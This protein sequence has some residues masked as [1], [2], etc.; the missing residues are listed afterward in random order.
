[1]WCRLV[2]LTGAEKWKKFAGGNYNTVV[3]LTRA[4]TDPAN[5]FDKLMSRSVGN[6]VGG[7][8][9]GQILGQ[10]PLPWSQVH[11][12][13][14]PKGVLRQINENSGSA[15]AFDFTFGPAASIT[16]DTDVVISVYVLGK[17]KDLT[18]KQLVGKQKVTVKKDPSPICQAP[19][20]AIVTPSATQAC[21]QGAEWSSE[22]GCQCVV[23]IC[24][25][26]ACASTLQ[27]EC[28]EEEEK[29]VASGPASKFSLSC[30]GAG[31]K[32]KLNVEIPDPSSGSAEQSV[33]IAGSAGECLDLKL[34]VAG[35]AVNRPAIINLGQK[36]AASM[37]VKWDAGTTTADFTKMTRPVILY[38]CNV[39]LQMSGQFEFAYNFIVRPAV[40]AG[41]PKSKVTL[42]RA[43]QA[44]D[45]KFIS[46]AGGGE[47]R[48]EG[49]P[50]I[51]AAGAKV[52]NL[53][54][55]GAGTETQKP[56]QSVGSKN[57]DGTCAAI[58]A[59]DDA[60][61]GGT[62][63]LEAIKLDCMNFKFE[64][65]TDATKRAIKQLEIKSSKYVAK[66]LATLADTAS[67]ESWPIVETL[68]LSDAVT[69]DLSSLE[70]QS[71]LSCTSGTC[72]A[73]TLVQYSAVGGDCTELNFNPTPD[74]S[75]TLSGSYTATIA[76]AG[77][78]RTGGKIQA[79]FSPK[80][81]STTGSTT[82]STGSNPTAPSPTT[83]ST[84]AVPSAPETVTADDGALSGGAIGGIIAAGVVFVLVVIIGL[85]AV[86]CMKSGNTSQAPKAL[87][88][89]IPAYSAVAYNPSYP[90]YPVATATP[91]G[92]SPTPA[93]SPQQAIAGTY[94]APTY[95]PV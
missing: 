71:A 72:T 52:K 74:L 56:M 92:P 38:L 83:S 1:M 9:S 90:A 47:L 4:T 69:F 65:S 48:F 94:S 86:W 58:G 25:N 73:I 18:T 95:T 5:L 77:T 44:I 19:N 75:S 46:K 8:P 16:A 34:N 78:R 93:V 6:A 11:V 2:P 14:S 85:V 30:T 40:D 33:D 29:A 20:A 15:K 66:G 53:Q 43:D 87:D 76:N 37:C 63:A 26:N 62:G 10:A 91:T 88:G 80:S 55:D 82:G 81:S 35:T 54:T 39:N 32:P 51:V 79:V 12:E 70:D 17:N 13:T 60:A 45:T 49:V 23:G 84:S 36:N 89:S 22:R 64:P 24:S 67:G 21:A 27:N 28:P 50:F 68:C 59:D 61:E 3:D 57:A 42:G 31:K 41:C 7:Y